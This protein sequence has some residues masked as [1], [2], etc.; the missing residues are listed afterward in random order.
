MAK[1]YCVIHKV[2]MGMYL[3]YMARDTCMRDQ[4]EVKQNQVAVSRV[5]VWLLPK[6]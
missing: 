2:A 4:R 3:E 5:H 6:H 1:G